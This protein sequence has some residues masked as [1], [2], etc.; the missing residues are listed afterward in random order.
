MTYVFFSVLYHGSHH[1]DFCPSHAD[2]DAQGQTAATYRQQQKQLNAHPYYWIGI[3]V[4]AFWIYDP[5]DCRFITNVHQW[6]F[7]IGL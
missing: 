1:V 4:A 7:E 5:E 2:K 3:T 6:R